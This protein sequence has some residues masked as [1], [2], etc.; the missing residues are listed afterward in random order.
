M[1]N[2]NTILKELASRTELLECNRSSG[3]S[4]GQLKELAMS[5]AV[6]IGKMMGLMRNAIDPVQATQLLQMV[7]N[8]PYHK[9]AVDLLRTSINHK[10]TKVGDSHVSA[11]VVNR[12]TPPKTALDLQ[13]C[14]HFDFY[15]KESQWVVIMDPEVDMMTKM[16]ILTDAAKALR[17]FKP[18]EKTFVH[19][20][21]VLILASVAKS[22]QG[23]NALQLVKDLKAALRG[24]RSNRQLCIDGAC[25]NYP[26][27]PLEFQ[28]QCP[29]VY[30]LA[31]SDAP[32]VASRLD[33]SQLKAIED[34]VPARGT[35]HSVNICKSMGSHGMK[36]QSENRMLQMVGKLLVE[37]ANGGGGGGGNEIGLQVF[38]ANRNQ[39]KDLQDILGRCDALLAQKKTDLMALEDASPAGVSVASPSPV[40]V[41]TSL[42]L[43]S[44][45]PVVAG[46]PDRAT[47]SADNAAPVVAG[48]PS[49][50]AGFA[51]MVTA[52]KK[53]LQGGCH[54]E[55]EEEEDEGETGA[56]KKAPKKR[57]RGDA[58]A[59]LTKA[60]TEKSA[61]ATK[62]KRGGGPTAL[63]KKAVIDISNDMKDF[64][65]PGLKA[66]VPKYYKGITIYTSVTLKKWRVKPCPK[67]RHE[68]KF[69]WGDSPRDTWLLVVKHVK[70]LAK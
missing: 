9:E 28:K 21:A 23:H 8:G 11:S 6:G 58:P 64:S 29:V 14:S 41:E 52:M 4:D 7:V 60:D 3:M 16:R 46:S 39:R 15:L 51:D 26:E 61:G 62:R 43:L 36:M 49:S 24:R 37:R 48:S 33:Q 57:K 2:F 65:Y 66:C 70:Q 69:S 25:T 56:E 31:Y 53:Q 34:M 67:A 20:A 59:A 30:D 50:A 32:P 19:M 40:G 13:S 45:A 54:E 42:A 12:L 22:T 68:K 38:G 35:H 47:G 5:A 55:E 44:P 17:L 10:V 1:E 27:S 63:D 18:S